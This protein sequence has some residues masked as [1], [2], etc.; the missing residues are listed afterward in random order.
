MEKNP[1]PFMRPYKKAIGRKH[2]TYNG[3]RPKGLDASSG[4]EFAGL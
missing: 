2:L 3:E 4:F 1:D